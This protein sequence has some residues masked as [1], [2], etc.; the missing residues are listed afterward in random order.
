MAETPLSVGE[1]TFIFH[2]VDVSKL[3]SMHNCLWQSINF[4][5]ICEYFHCLERNVLFDI[6]N[7]FFPW[8]IRFQC[9]VMKF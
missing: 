8:N 4:E 9:I 3:D 1:K 6:L 7:H 2:G 5:R